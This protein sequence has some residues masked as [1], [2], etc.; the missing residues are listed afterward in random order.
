MAQNFQ[1]TVITPER[2]VIDTPAKFVAL[3]AHDGEIGIL[4]NRAPLVCKL[5]VGVL[6]IETDAGMKRLYVDGGFAQVLHNQ[7]TVLT[8]K[9]LKPEEVNPAA[10]EKALAEA[11]SRPARKDEEIDARQNDVARAKAQL[12]LARV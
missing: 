7:V 2:L 11:N 5:G 6:R 4:R 10:A 8:A 9:A 3:P 12:K 1:C